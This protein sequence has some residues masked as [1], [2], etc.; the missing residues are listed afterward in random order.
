MIV[1][2]KSHVGKVRK[3]N[4]DS[5]YISEDN[6]LP[7]FIIADGM[8]GHKAGEVA[9]KMAIDIVREY[10]YENRSKLNSKEDI[11]A[12]I[13][14]AIEKAN[15]KIY[16]KSGEEDQF[17]GMGTTLILAYIK[18]E[19]LYIGHVGDSRAYLIGKDIIQ[20]TED[21]SFVNQ[22]MKTG[23]LSIE[24]A[25]NH[26]KK[27]LITRAVGSSSIINID[28]IYQDISKAS[29]LLVMTD[30]VT[31]ML[32]DKFLYDEFKNSDNMQK[33]CDTI[34]AA[35]NEQGGIDNST[36]VAV[37]FSNEVKI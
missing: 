4:Q 20:I 22:M 26:P 18:E 17:E 1:G 25:K 14:G 16:L 5:F 31:N 21:H 27:N 36:I 33:S 11:F 19:Q 24:E 9:S 13:K 32:D 30:G 23:N 3:I 7:F 34:I 8:G 28:L 37:K 35:A 10:F 6:N 2:A 12:T 29:I 15:T